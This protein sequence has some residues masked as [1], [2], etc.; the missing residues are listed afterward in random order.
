MVNSITTFSAF[1]GEPAGDGQSGAGGPFIN[2]LTEELKQSPGVGFTDVTR[3]TR[4]RLMDSSPHCQ[5]AQDEDALTAPLVLNLG[6]HAARSGG[7]PVQGTPARK[8][9]ACTFR[10]TGEVLASAQVREGAMAM[11][12]QWAQNQADDAPRRM[13]V[14][15]LGGAGL[16]ARGEDLRREPAVLGE[17]VDEREGPEAGELLRSKLLAALLVKRLDGGAR[18]GHH[19][20]RLDGVRC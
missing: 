18:A 15:G 2:I 20:A 8:A 17:A 6:L 10:V 14:H 4:K 16:G 19:G 5:L 1:S 9:A 12:W 11:L 3:R 13:L 7:H